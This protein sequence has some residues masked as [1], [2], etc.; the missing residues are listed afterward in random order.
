MD[1]NLKHQ[2]HYE[3]AAF[4]KLIN[5]EFPQVVWPRLTRFVLTTTSHFSPSWARLGKCGQCI[6]L[7]TTIKTGSRKEKMAAKAEL[8][9][10]TELFNAE[11]EGYHKCIE[12]ARRNPSGHMSIIIDGSSP[13]RCSYLHLRCM[14]MFASCEGANAM[15]LSFPQGL[16][17]EP[18]FQ[19]V[20]QWYN[21]SW[22]QTKNFVVAWI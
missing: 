17:K 13:V 4:S 14:L 12:K 7:G 18:S 21:R 6:K 2:P 16:S 8:K 20:H 11:R 9:K 1:T 22:F 5:K 15:Y 3:Y 19:A 10:H